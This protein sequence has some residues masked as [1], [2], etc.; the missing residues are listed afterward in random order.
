MDLAYI[1]VRA[2]SAEDTFWNNLRA[3][4]LQIVDVTA[5]ESQQGTH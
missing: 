5:D 3:L 2:S 4:E 1:F